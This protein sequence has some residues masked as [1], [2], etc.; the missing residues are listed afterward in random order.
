LDSFLETHIFRLADGGVQC[1]ERG[2]FIGSTPILRRSRDPGGGGTWF[3][4]PSDELDRELSKA[5]GLPIDVAAKREAL[6]NVATALARG[7][8]AFAQIAALLLRFP[9]PPSPAK[10]ASAP[11]SLELAKRLF[12][13]GLLKGGWDESLH[14]RTGQPPNRGWF[15]TKPDASDEGALKPHADWPSQTINFVIRSGALEWVLRVAETDPRTRTAAM[16]VDLTIEAIVWLRQEFPDEDVDA[17]Q[18]RAADQ[19]YTNLLPPKTLTELQ[20]QP[21]DHLLGYE[22]HHIVEENPANIAKDDR[23][24]AEPA[25]KFGYDALDDPSNIVYAPRLKHEQIT[26][27]YN[28]SYLSNSA[29]PRTRVVVSSM[30]FNAQRE[31]GLQALRE[32]GVLQ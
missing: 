14:P 12:D 31:V 23:P 4:R 30:D 6:T 28:R 26:A 13:S 18:V 20:T 7:D 21:Q 9:D 19:I 16:I 15:A 5:Y 8:L 24:V 2:L 11:S 17:G 27:A 25:R 3:V 29:Y 10:G 32:V 22:R 1:D